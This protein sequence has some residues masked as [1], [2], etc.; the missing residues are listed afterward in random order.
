MIEMTKPFGEIMEKNNDSF[1]IE[2]TG[3]KKKLILKTA[4][5]AV[6]KTFGTEIFSKEING[7]FIEFLDML[8][9]TRNKI[10]HVK[11]LQDKACLDGVQCVFYIA[12]LSI[13]YRKI[14]FMLIGIDDTM[15]TD[16]IIKAVKAL[17]NWYYEKE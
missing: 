15:Y 8:V 11:S 1:Q 16:N 17:D 12:K 3:D 4:L 10:S 13:M 2:R 5:N 14:I 9:N 7:N 6:I